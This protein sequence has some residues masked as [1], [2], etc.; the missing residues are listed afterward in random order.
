MLNLGDPDD[1][2]FSSSDIDFRVNGE[3]I[4]LDRIDFSGDVVSLKGKGWMDLNRQI[5]LD[6]YALVGREEFQL[7]FVKALLAQAS[8][9]IL[10]IQVVG[11][12][13]QPQVIRKP[14]PDLDETLQRIFPESAPR[15]ASPQPLW[16]HA[17]K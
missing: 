11:T 16:G 13:D 1:T 3:V 12:V 10:L 14:L 2:A 8:K 7:P 5:D 17:N 6:F 4:H 9:S 15:T